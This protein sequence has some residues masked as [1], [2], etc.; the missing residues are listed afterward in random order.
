MEGSPGEFLRTNIAYFREPGQASF[1][2]KPKRPLLSS[3]N[4]LFFF[5]LTEN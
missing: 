4:A 3:V 2:L 1:G 5:V